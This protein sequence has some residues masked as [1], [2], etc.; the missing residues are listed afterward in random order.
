MKILLLSFYNLGKQPKII[1][2]LYNKLNH[3]GIKIDVFDYSIKNYKLDF[4]NYDAIGLYASMHTA[5]VLATEYLMEKNLP[6]K[7]FTF[8]LYGKVLSDSD[9]RITYL[10]NLDGSDFEIYLGININSNFT[11]KNSIPDRSSFPEISKY[12]K[13]VN[14]DKILY[15]GSVETTYGCKHV[16]THCPVPIQFNGRFKTFSEEKI[17]G[18]ISNQI[19]SGAQHISFDDADFFNGPKYSLRILEKLYK[20]FPNITYDATIKVEHIIKYQK[21]FKELTNLNM[22]FVTSAFET[23]N[24]TVLEILKKNHTYKDLEQSIS[25]SKQFD[26]DIRPTWM[27]FT[28]W[29]NTVD[30]INIVSLIEQYELRETVDPIQLAIKLLVPKGSLMI[31]RPEFSKYIGKYDQESFTYLWHYE[32][33]Q[34]EQLQALLFGYVVEHDNINEKEQYLELI[35]IIQSFTKTNIIYNKKYN[36]REVPKLSETWFCCAEPNK[37]QLQRI[38]SNES[39]M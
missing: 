19:E 3:D 12:S 10:E 27:P 14:G 33:S 34:V 7:V 8:G 24:N 20:K 32:D 4:E 37:I 6:D 11:I 23:T 30:L 5:T 9:I 18:D 26:I 39:L 25:L 31:K 22:L 2:E 38:K 35:D 29:T 13:L 21:Y 15:T 17:I 28:P 16:C 36:Y 1:G